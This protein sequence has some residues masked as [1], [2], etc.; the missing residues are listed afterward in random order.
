MKN[1]FL[2]FSL[3]TLLATSGISCVS[4][5]DFDIPPVKSALF[6]EDFNDNT[7]YETPLN[8]EG[9]STVAEAGTVV[10]RE[11]VFTDDNAGYAEFSSFNSGQ[12]S[13]IAWL[14][15]PAINLEGG[16]KKLTFQ[17]AQH[18]LESASN[19]IEVFVST[20][21]DG[22][23]ATTANWQPLT[24]NFADMDNDWYEYVNSGTIDLSNYNG[25]IFIGFKA[26]GNGTTLAGG[27]Q[28]DN[29]IVY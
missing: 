23:N 7:N 21:Y 19:T 16:E 11:R 13:N 22:T 18:H 24:A 3:I 4:E 10:W 26:T 17:S 25:E 8:T 5:D 6:F 9:W 27:F 28:I 20:D 15:T 1:I 14:I 12:P 2:K 29:V